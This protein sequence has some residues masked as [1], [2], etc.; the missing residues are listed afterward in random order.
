MERR[1]RRRGP[2]KELPCVLPVVGFDKKWYLCRRGSVCITGLPPPQFER[3]SRARLY[4]AGSATDWPAS[5][6]KSGARPPIFMPGGAPSAHAICMTFWCR[7]DPKCHTLRPKWAAVESRQGSGWRIGE[8]RNQA[9]DRAGIEAIRCSDDRRL[10]GVSGV[11]Q[12]DAPSDRNERVDTQSKL[13]NYSSPGQAELW[14]SMR[15]FRAAPP[16]RRWRGSGQAP[17]RWRDRR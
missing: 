17:M 14:L 15:K 11:R 7:E 9:V 2:R 1:A 12:V 3:P 5:M 8:C 13:E 4:A 10:C 16:E 6:L